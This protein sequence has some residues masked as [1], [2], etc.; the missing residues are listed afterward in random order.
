MLAGRRGAVVH[1]HESHAV[2]VPVLDL[3]A[4]G[5]VRQETL[6]EYPRAFDLRR[7]AELGAVAPLGDIEMVNSPV[8]DHAHAVVGDAVPDAPPFLGVRAA[9][10]VTV[11]RHWR[12]AEP[13]EIGRAHV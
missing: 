13:E 3:P 5:A 12:R 7:A 2:G 9:A 4:H 1:V 6:G 11:R 8:A 10:L